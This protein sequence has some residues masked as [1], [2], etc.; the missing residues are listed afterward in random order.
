MPAAISDGEL[1]RLD[2]QATEFGAEQLNDDEIYE[3][4]HE[5]HLALLAALCATSW[6]CA[7]VHP[8]PGIPSGTSGSGAGKLYTSTRTQHRRARRTT[9]SW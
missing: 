3:A 5:F 9:S 7:S 1:N 4:H 8:V 2:K 6:N